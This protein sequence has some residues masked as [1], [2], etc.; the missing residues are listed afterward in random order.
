[1]AN[2]TVEAPHMYVVYLWMD[3]ISDNEFMQFVCR[4]CERITSGLNAKCYRKKAL[5]SRCCWPKPH[6]PRIMAYFG[7]GVRIQII[8]A[9]FLP[10]TFT[11][12]LYANP[13]LEAH[14]TPQEVNCSIALY[15]W[16]SNANQL[17]TNCF[18]SCCSP[19]IYHKQWKT[20]NWILSQTITHL[21][22]RRTLTHKTNSN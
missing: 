15:R 17:V 9:I 7:E 4:G 2:D 5:E 19:H 12:H 22:T 8:G 6:F 20:R 14:P 13:F 10:N 3:K 11:A 1:M 21:R 16:F 18:L